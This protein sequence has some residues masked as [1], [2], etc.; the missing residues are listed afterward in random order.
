MRK[1]TWHTQ[2]VWKLLK[3]P[4]SKLQIWNLKISSFG[5]PKCVPHTSFRVKDL[6]HLFVIFTHHRLNEYE[7]IYDRTFMLLK[8]FRTDGFQKFSC[9]RIENNWSFRYKILSHVGLSWDCW[10]FNIFWAF[11]LFWSCPTQNL[12]T[13]LCIMV[14]L[15]IFK[16]LWSFII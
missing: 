16:K 10:N 7:W 4:F 3:L 15:Q 13:S 8:D 12:S 5:K 6:G 9:Y 1:T 2:K 11:Y 14:L